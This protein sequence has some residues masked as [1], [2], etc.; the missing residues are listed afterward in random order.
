M[1]EPATWIREYE[2]ARE[3]AQRAERGG[4]FEE[5][6][7][8]YEQSGQLAQA[9]GESGRA[10]LE[11][12]NRCALLIAL[13][14]SR[15]T[16]TVL[17]AVLER[18][19]GGE[20]GFL[21]AYNLACAHYA[22]R[23]HGK[24]AFYARGAI[25]LAETLDRQ[26]WRAWAHNQLANALL[27][28]D[29]VRDAVKGYEQALT[30]GEGSDLLIRGQMVANLGYCRV[31]LGAGREAFRELF[32]GFR[33]LRRAGAARAVM[34]GHLDLAFAYL[35]INRPEAALGHATKGLALAHEHGASED[36]RNAVF[37]L[38]EAHIGLGD[39]AA[40][41]ECFEQIQGQYPGTPYLTE[42]L[43]AVD[44]KSLVN[45]RA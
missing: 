13:G 4:A 5:A 27:S 30:L 39:E 10:D 21:A 15:E 19:S 35:E 32:Q 9:A 26:E 43:L 36:L 34:L 45:L 29:Q 24:A 17:R 16:V 41:R 25:R 40:A 6:L 12:C 23:E 33:M 14:R 31:L 44:L 20:N 11:E 38:G 22:L 3:Q 7:H 1:S 18:N 28:R 8:W 2:Q 37:L 42:L